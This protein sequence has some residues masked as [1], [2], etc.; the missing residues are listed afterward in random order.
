[1]NPWLIIAVLAGA[2]ALAGAAGWQGY[3]MGHATAEA[4]HNLERLAMI[5][6]GHKLDQARR[7]LAQQRDD[8]ADELEAKGNADPV[9]VERCLSSKRVFRLNRLR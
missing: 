3:R 9:T 8:L 6:A 2:I 5:E 7:L 1:M 4:K